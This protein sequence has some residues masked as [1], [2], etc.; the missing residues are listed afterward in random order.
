MFSRFK[1]GSIQ[2]S[3]FKN[4][5]LYALGEIILVVAGILIALQ[6][7]NSNQ[8]ALKKEQE[9]KILSEINI[10]LI[11]DTVNLAGFNQRVDFNT[12]VISSLIDYLSSDK[13][14]KD[15]LDYYFPMV[16][17]PFMWSESNS[18]YKTL[19]SKGLDLVSNDEI[20]NDII[21]INTSLYETIKYLDGGV[22][23]KYP[24]IH[25]YCLKHFDVVGSEGV[26]E[27]G[28]YSAAKMKPNNYEELKA[29]PEFLT[30]LRTVKQQN[31]VFLNILNATKNKVKLTI[32]KIEEEI[33]A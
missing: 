25:E 23:I 22:Y 24:Y 2:K 30:I 21:V 19:L 6:V 31:G 11:A 27:N 29:D 12:K 4:Y 5:L 14:Y 33:K 18:A 26:D 13:P 28:K 9:I 1:S 32:E 7:N 10:A 8:N 3:K 20:R 17:T 15:S 16:V